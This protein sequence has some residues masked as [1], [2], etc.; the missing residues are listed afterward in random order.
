M[1]LAQGIQ[2]IDQYR[3]S[4]QIEGLLSTTDDSYSKVN[5]ESTTLEKEDGDIDGPFDVAV[6]I[7]EEVRD[8]ETTQIVY[9]SSSY[10]TEDQVNQMVSGENI[11]LIVDCLNQMCD[12]ENPISIYSKD[13]TVSYL[14]WTGHAA[15]SWSLLLIAG[16]P[17]AILIFGVVIW[18][19]RRKL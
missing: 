10:I 1:P 3:D 5:V 15:G 13:L 4:L 7:T 18:F 9:F 2:T 19:R 8:D 11:D 17:G 6:S 12:T 16:I 14:T